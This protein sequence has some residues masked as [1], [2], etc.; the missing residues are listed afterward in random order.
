MNRMRAVALAVT[1][2][3]LAGVL[4][5][6]P[7]R[8]DLDVSFG[9]FY[10][11]L[12][13]HGSWLVS[14]QYGRVWQ[15]EVYVGGWNPYYDG[16]WVYTDLGWSWVSDYGW[17]AIP[18]HYGTWAFDPVFGWVWVPGYVWAPAWVVFRTGPDYIGWAPVSPRFSIGISTS[19]GAPSAD[20]FVFV[21]A[22]NFVAP[23]IRTVRV[24]RAR[25]TV[26]FNRTRVV[27]NLV[28]ENNIVVN[29]GPDVRTIERAS[30][31]KVRAVSIENVRGVAPRGRVTKDDLRFDRRRNAGGVRA[32]EPVSE[33]QPLPGRAR[34]TRDLR[35]REGVGRE[36]GGSGVQDRRTKKREEPR[37]SGEL[38]PRTRTRPEAGVA[39]E[40]SRPSRARSP[41]SDLNGGRRS[42]QREPSV[43]RQQ[44]S[45][46]KS[47]DAT[48]PKKQKRKQEGKEPEKGREGRRRGG[49]E[50]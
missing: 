39:P 20:A 11:N 10:S 9:F 18:Y 38:S 31:K 17:G 29:R 40:M 48:A 15:P 23:R 8:A 47:K 45:P 16:H 46:P 25:T 30:G 28:V 35:R 7:A 5:P 44:E 42:G 36:S 37:S 12:S 4:S 27:N 13:P 14:T 50:S 32:A 21:S 1:L 22:G 41:E 43:R 2:V 34:G 49:G 24:P 3:L 33:N 19:F 6:A 26:V